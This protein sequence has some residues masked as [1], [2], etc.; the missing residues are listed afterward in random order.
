[1]ISVAICDDNELQREILAELVTHYRDERGTELEAEQFCSGNELKKAVGDG[2]QYDI[3]LLDIIME[4]INGLETA[5]MLR[6]SGCD[7]HII[8]LTASPEYAIASYEVNALYY[9]LKPVDPDKFFKILDLA[10]RKT[11]VVAKS[12][13]IKLKT[14]RISLPVE[15]IAY[16]DTAD[17]KLCYHLRDGRDVTSTTMHTPFKESIAPLLA[18]SRFQLISVSTAVNLTCVR[19]FETSRLTLRDGVVLFPSR[20]YIN[21]LEDAWLAYKMG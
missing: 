16:V 2:K 11:D 13:S 8:F 14:G 9:M 5:A 10:V 7:G 20:S 1:M 15:Q 17:R 3:Y 21:E 6:A 18:D 12:F 19:R 4:G